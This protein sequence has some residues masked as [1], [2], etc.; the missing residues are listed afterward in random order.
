VLSNGVVRLRQPLQSDYIAW[1]AEVSVLNRRPVNI[2]TAS[3][4]VLELLFTN[5]QLR[6]VNDR[7]VKS[8]AK[9]LAELVIE[10][11]PFTGEEDFLRRV[12]LPAAG[13]E[14]LPNGAATP[15]ALAGDTTLISANDALALYANGQNANDVGLAFSTMPY[16]FTSRDVYGV[17]VR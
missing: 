10:S 8:E 15:S 17:E 7:I 9:A 11:R 5:L 2:N 4:D 1:Q 3:E 6:G 12:V 13:I 14:K 16:S